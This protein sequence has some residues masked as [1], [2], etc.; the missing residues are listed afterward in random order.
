[1]TKNPNLQN[2]NTSNIVTE[3]AKHLDKLW[4]KARDVCDEFYE[5]YDRGYEEL[6]NEPFECELSNA[7]IR[8][9]DGDRIAVDYSAVHVYNSCVAYACGPHDEEKVNVDRAYAR[10]REACLEDAEDHAKRVLGEYRRVIARWARKRGINYTEELR[11]DE[12]NF[13]L[14]VKPHPAG[15]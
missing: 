6:E 10:C 15:E 13:T 8:V 12:L 3:L 9:D 7:G 4:S 5:E 1:M 2:V 14:V 11:R